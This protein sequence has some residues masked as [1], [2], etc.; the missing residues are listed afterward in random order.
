MDKPWSWHPGFL[1]RASKAPQ[2]HK[3]L[4]F[5]LLYLSLRLMVAGGLAGA[6]GWG[7]GL[8]A[9]SALL[10]STLLSR[11]ARTMTFASAPGPSSSAQF[12]GDGPYDQRLGYA[13]L[14]NYIDA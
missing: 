9:R 14:P 13:Q 3:R 4:V 8:E 5:R 1:R 12:P 2:V 10:Q 6:I 7:A 11:W